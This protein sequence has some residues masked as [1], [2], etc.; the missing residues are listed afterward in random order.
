MSLYTFL[1]IRKPSPCFLLRRLVVTNWLQMHLHRDGLYTLERETG[2]EPATAC[3]EGRRLQNCRSAGLHRPDSRFYT[4]YVHCEWAWQKTS[5][6]FFSPFGKTGH[7]VLP[8]IVA[9]DVANILW[10]EVTLLNTLYRISLS[11]AMLSRKEV[12]T[13]GVDASLEVRNAR[14]A[15]SAQ[16]VH[17]VH[18]FT[19][20]RTR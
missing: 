1:Y 4:V 20:H 10:Q 16:A 8:P 2:L 17:I 13:V 19:T 3:L 18:L 5:R 6:A 7:V 9:K 11:L 12:L 15:G 14:E